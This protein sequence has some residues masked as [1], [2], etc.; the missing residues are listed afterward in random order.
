MEA[1]PR[2]WQQAGAAGED[3]KA[4]V[5]G[6]KEEEQAAIAMAIATGAAAATEAGNWSAGEGWRMED[7]GYGDGEARSVEVQQRRRHQTILQHNPFG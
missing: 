1:R 3:A 4:V 2:S 6:S 5:A 7:D